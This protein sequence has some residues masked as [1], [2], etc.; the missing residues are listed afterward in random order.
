MTVVIHCVVGTQVNYAR[1]QHNI[2]NDQHNLIYEAKSVCSLFPETS[3][4]Q[5]IWTKFGVQRPYISRMVKGM[6]F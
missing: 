1:Y 2:V 5:R 4:F 3:Q 6:E